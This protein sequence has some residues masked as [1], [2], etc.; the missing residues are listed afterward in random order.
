MSVASVGSLAS[1]CQIPELQMCGLDVRRAQVS[2]WSAGVRGGQAGKGTGAPRAGVL[3]VSTCQSWEGEEDIKTSW[4]NVAPPPSPAPATSC[5]E[6]LTLP[7]VGHTHIPISDHTGTSL[8]SWETAEYMVSSPSPPPP[9]SSP[10][11]RAE[12]W[13]SGELASCQ[14]SPQPDKLKSQNLTKTLQVDHHICLPPWCLALPREI[15]CYFL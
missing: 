11:Y 3:G 15:A 6:V 5:R 12:T 10:F 9:S 8:L 2:R 13:G 14:R 4:H 1:K 7:P